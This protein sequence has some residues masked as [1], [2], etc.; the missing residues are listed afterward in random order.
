M[1]IGIAMGKQ[2]HTV[3]CTYSVPLYASHIYA[4][5]SQSYTVTLLWLCTKDVLT[6]DMTSDYS[7]DLPVLL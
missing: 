5:C 2:G 7:M 1:A 3:V 4:M 6:E